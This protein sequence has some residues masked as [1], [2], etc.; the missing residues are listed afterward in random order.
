[1]RNHTHVIVAV[2]TFHRESD[3]SQCAQFSEF[4]MLKFR[5]VAVRSVK[6]VIFHGMDLQDIHRAHTI[7]HEVQNRHGNESPIKTIT[8]MPRSY[9]LL[10]RRRI[11]RV[12]F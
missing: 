9:S 11:G 5:V 2:V 1:M 6:W 4:P 10:P 8:L 12:S 7:W 3:F